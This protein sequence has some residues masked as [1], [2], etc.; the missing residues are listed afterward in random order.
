MKLPTIKNSK[1]QED[2]KEHKDNFF[3]LIF[4]DP[5]YQL[6]TQWEIDKRTGKPKVKGKSK[7]FMNKWEGLDEND[8]NLFFEQS[9]RTLK[10]G[11]FLL[12]FGLDRQL[13]P[14]EY[15]ARLKAFVEA[16]EKGRTEEQIKK[17]EKEKKDCSSVSLKEWIEEK[18]YLEVKEGE[19]Q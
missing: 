14:L 5:P 4:C 1:F 16:K 10:Q 19:K 11:G 8:L 12:M 7:D 2:M 9:F 18:N 13:M 6:G 17:I 15:Y 3:N